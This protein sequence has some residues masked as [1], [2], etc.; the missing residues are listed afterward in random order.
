[1]KPIT[2]HWVVH[3]IDFSPSAL[4]GI[5]KKDC[6]MSVQILNLCDTCQS[7]HPALVTLSAADFMFIFLVNLGITT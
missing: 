7:K 1:M 2:G 3:S 5:K 6:N 4:T